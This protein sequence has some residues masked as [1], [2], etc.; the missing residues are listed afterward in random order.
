MNYPEEAALPSRS[1]IET[2][3]FRRDIQATR[4]TLP[5]GAKPR[6]FLGRVRHGQ[7]SGRQN[8]A[9]VEREL[10][11]PRLD[12]RALSREGRDTANP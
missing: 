1:H 3:M 11:P 4:L 8:L 7:T 5:R 2:K 9:R 12:L 10:C 6:K